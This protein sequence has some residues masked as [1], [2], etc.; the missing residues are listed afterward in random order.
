MVG[1]SEGTWKK[2]EVKLE[3]SIISTWKETK[4]FLQKMRKHFFQL[5]NID[6]GL[7]KIILK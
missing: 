6:G 3:E 5:S 1:R 2:M 4:V 7:W